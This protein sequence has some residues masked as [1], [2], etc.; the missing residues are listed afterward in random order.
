MLQL[1]I[2]SGYTETVL[3]LSIVS[4]RKSSCDGPRVRVRKPHTARQRDFT[5]QLVLSTQ[6]MLHYFSLTLVG[7]H[8]L[9]R[10]RRIRLPQSILACR[11]SSISIPPPARP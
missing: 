7:K 10:G 11:K 5:V 1:T 4:C 2:C 8:I 9:R 6:M 3:I